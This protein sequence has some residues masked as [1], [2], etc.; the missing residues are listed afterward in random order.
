LRTPSPK[1]VIARLESVILFQTLEGM[2]EVEIEISRLHS[3]DASD[4]LVLQVTEENE[5][6]L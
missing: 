1:G 4:G 2:A 6:G 3:G 5:V